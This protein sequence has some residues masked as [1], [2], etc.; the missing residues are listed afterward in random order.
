MRPLILML[1]ILMS[2]QT[3]ATAQNRQRANQS[4]NALDMAQYTPEEASALQTKR[5]TLLLDLNEK[6]QAQVQKIQLENAI[7]RK[8]L[9]E[10]NQAKNQDGERPRLTKEERLANQN[11]MLDHQIAMKAKMKNILTEA[12]FAKWEEAQMQRRSNFNENKPNRKTRG[13]N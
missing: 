1:L 8:A 13:R 9:R 11:A 7:Q 2:V 12:Q 4:Q 10:A 6:Q 5:M 3:V